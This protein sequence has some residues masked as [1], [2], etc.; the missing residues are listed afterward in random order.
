MGLGSETAGTRHGDRGVGIWSSDRVNQ[1]ATAC[2]VCA[3]IIRPENIS[4][5]RKEK[6]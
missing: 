1:Q 4:C 2:L 3:T 6:P 5:L